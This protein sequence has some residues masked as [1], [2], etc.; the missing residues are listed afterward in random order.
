LEEAAQPVVAH[1]P[2]AAHHRPRQGRPPDRLRPGRD[3]RRADAGGGQRTHQRA[4]ARAHDQVRPDPGLLQHRENADVR[5]AARGAATQDQPEPRPLPHTN[6]VH[7]TALHCRP[8]VKR[9]A[10]HN[11]ARCFVVRT[12]SRRRIT[13]SATERNLSRSYSADSVAVPHVNGGTYFGGMPGPTMDEPAPTT[14][15]VFRSV[16]IPVLTWSPSRQPSLIAPA[17][18]SP[19]GVHTRTGP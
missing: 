6:S 18:T 5:D 14:V 9:Q 2:R 19:D 8:R 1:E 3:P 12:T 13:V 16:P 15:P 11:R 10:A 17:S 7:P 4:G